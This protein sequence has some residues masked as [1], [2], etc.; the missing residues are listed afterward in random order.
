MLEGLVTTPTTLVAHRPAQ[1]FLHAVL[2]SCSL[3]S[4]ILA[5][6]AAIKSHTLKRPVLSLSPIKQLPCL[7]KITIA[8][9][10]PAMHWSDS[11]FCQACMHEYV[12]D[13]SDWML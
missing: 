13:P 1:K 11:G 5:V 2:H 10:S 8:V 4:L 12:N 7:H 6:T 3:I 9:I